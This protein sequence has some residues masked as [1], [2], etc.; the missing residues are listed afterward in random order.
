MRK[1]VRL[2]YEFNERLERQSFPLAIRRGLTSIIPFLLLGSIALLV[3]SLPIPAYQSLMNRVFG[4]QWKDAFLYVR[5]GTFNIAAL[6]TV[7]CIGYANSVEFIERYH[8]DTSP[9]IVA[10]V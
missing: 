1:V 2:L 5:D 4:V 7:L 10:T 6:I 9:I 8:Q 3:L